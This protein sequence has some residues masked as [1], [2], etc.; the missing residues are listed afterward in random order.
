VTAVYTHDFADRPETLLARRP[1]RL[2][3]PLAASAGYLPSGPLK[4]LT[5][6]NGLSETRTFTS[7]YFPSSIALTGISQLLNWTYSTDAAG[8]ILSITDNLTPAASRTYGYQDIHYFLT[9]GDGPWGP[10]SWTYD[11]IGNRLTETR[12]AVSDTYSY[13]P[14]S[15]G[16]RSPILSQIQ[17]GAGG[18]RT[19]QFG[20][21]GHLEQVTLGTASTLY[22]SDAAGRLSTLENPGSQSGATFRYDGRDYLTQAASGVMPRFGGCFDLEPK[23]ER[24]PR[25]PIPRN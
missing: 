20:P 16:G 8:N 5:L 15:T 14:S 19:Y 18:T 6:G 9:R 25:T 7:R 3:Q 22:R 10:R 24:P 23:P 17:L 13:L 12:G 2:D 4:S 1:G 21:A 11:K